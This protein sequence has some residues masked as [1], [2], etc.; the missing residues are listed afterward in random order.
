MQVL[1][2]VDDSE[3][4]EITL[5]NVEAMLR[6]GQETSRVF[7]IEVVVNGAAVRELQLA[8]AKRVGTY[9]R[10]AALGAAVRVC[11]C[12]NALANLAIS[13][14]SLLPGVAVVPAGV[15]EIAER[16]SEGYAYIKP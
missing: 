9:D 8:Q 2:H 4:W 14:E 11:A 15:V 3:R 5:N 16:Q 12:K 10:L 1:F 13:P 6:C 7:T